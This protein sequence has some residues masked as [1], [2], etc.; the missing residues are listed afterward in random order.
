MDNSIPWVVMHMLTN[1]GKYSF[2]LSYIVLKYPWIMEHYQDKKKFH[3]L[4]SI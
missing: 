2:T 4:L 1:S 3:L